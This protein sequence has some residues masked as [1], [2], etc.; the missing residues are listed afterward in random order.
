MSLVFPGIDSFLMFIRL[1]CSL[2]WLAFLKIFFHWLVF[3][4]EDFYYA[5]VY[6]KI[7]NDCR[8]LS[9]YFDFS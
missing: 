2:C 6:M 3:L 9:E 1:L 5:F 7:L 8:N 4:H